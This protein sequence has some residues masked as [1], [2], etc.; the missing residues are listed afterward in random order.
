LRNVLKLTKFESVLI[1][2]IVLKIT[3]INVRDSL[4]ILAERDKKQVL[5]KVVMIGAIALVVLLAGPLIGNALA[6]PIDVNTGISNAQTAADTAFMLIS[7]ALVLL[8]TPGLA[9]FYGGFVRS[10]NVLNTLMM[11]FVLMGIVDFVGL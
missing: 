8:M 7:A 10:R 6:A 2:K 11:S 9:F 5:K 1:Q 4:K 3:Q